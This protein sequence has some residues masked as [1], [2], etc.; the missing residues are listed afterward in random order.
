MA[1][2]EGSIV[3]QAFQ[4]L[5]APMQALLAEEMALTGVDGQLYE[6]CPIRGGPAFLIYYGPALLQRCRGVEEMSKGLQILAAIFAA[7]RALW[8]RSLEEQ[9]S[10][11]VINVGQLRKHDVRGII[12]G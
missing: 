8:P 3:L 11:V 2:N 9:G 6:S 1:Q 10:T 12:A 7:G 5:A 4:H